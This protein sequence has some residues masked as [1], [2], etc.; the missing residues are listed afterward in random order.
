MCQP[1]A[2]EVFGY[3]RFKSYSLTPVQGNERRAMPSQGV[4]KLVLAAT[5]VL[6]NRRNLLAL[7][8]LARV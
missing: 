4:G 3:S 2:A 5:R 6:V 7:V 8:Q 1:A